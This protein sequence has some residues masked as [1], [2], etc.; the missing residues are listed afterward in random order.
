VLH[1]VFEDANNTAWAGEIQ[2]F[3]VTGWQVY[4]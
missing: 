4:L 2:Q 3:C 1:S